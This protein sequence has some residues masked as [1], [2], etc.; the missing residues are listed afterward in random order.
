MMQA[1]AS[2][3]FP[4]LYER[5][6]VPGKFDPWARDLIERARPIGPSDRVLDLGCGTGIVA[7]RL[8]DRLGG[9]ARITGL[10]ASA[11]MIAQARALAPEIDWQVGNAMALPSGDGSFD[12]VLCQQMLQFVG[13]RAAAAREMRRVLAP[14]GRLLLSTWRA[15]SEQ[16]MYEVV[17]RIAE[18]HLGAASDRRFSL[19]DDAAL[20]TLLVDA[21]FAD[22][23]VQVVTITERSAEFPTLLNVRAMG[24]DL[25][26]LPDAERE[27]RLAAVETETTAALA[28]FAGDGGYLEPA[29]ANIATAIVA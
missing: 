29:R 12:L 23:A 17:C 10:D 14:G 9:G 8:R 21:G 27:R 3:T 26:S 15:R 2:P 20:R 18:R 16:P 11:Q 13:D 22:V 24:F 6:V 4:E 5:L 19:G 7:R 1:I 28:R 25:E